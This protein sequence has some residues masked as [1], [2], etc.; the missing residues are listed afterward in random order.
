[1][2]GHIVQ[3]VSHHHACNIDGIGNYYGLDNCHFCDW[4]V[5]N[6]FHH[7]HDPLCLDIIAS[8]GG[9]KLSVV[10]LVLASIVILLSPSPIL[11]TSMWFFTAVLAP[12]GSMTSIVTSVVFVMIVI[13]NIFILFFLFRGRWLR[14]LLW[15]IF[16]F[17]FFPPLPLKF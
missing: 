7:G 10:T 4:E 5:C 13:V 11:G 2:E 9:I 16:T 1:M 6:S 8:V 3:P 15:F 14:Q 17:T 12:I